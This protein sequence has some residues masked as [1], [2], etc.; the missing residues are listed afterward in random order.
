MHIHVPRLLVEQ[1]G[2]QSKRQE[3][4]D[5]LA[6]VVYL[7]A[8]RTRDEDF[9][10]LSH[11]FFGLYVRERSF[12]AL[13]RILL[14]W[15]ILECDGK[16]SARS[17]KKKSFGYRMTEAAA[18]SGL[19]P[20]EISSATAL[21]R[22]RQEAGKSRYRHCRLPVHRRL[23]DSL[24]TVSV[25]ETAANVAI[26][27]LDGEAK[28]Y[29]QV[30]VD[31]I[32]EKDFHWKPCPYDR[33]HSNITRLKRELRRCLQFEG[34]CL[35]EADIAC[36]QPL[37]LAALLPEDVRRSEDGKFYSELCQ[38]GELH[39]F[40]QTSL[41]LADKDEAKDQLFKYLF[42]PPRRNL[43]ISKLF[44]ETFSTI[45]AFVEATK[46]G[47][48]FQHYK[49][50]AQTMQRKEA[51]IVIQTICAELYARFPTIE[52]LTVHDSLLTTEKY[53]NEVVGVMRKIIYNTIDIQPQIRV[54][55]PQPPYERRFSPVGELCEATRSHRPTGVVR[56]CGCI[57]LD[58]AIDTRCGPFSWLSGHTTAGVRKTGRGQ[59]GCPC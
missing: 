35:F 34:K 36:S 18:M 56:H 55:P 6:L 7:V 57:R 50:L 2:F 14:A 38:Q 26:G 59:R 40:I 44:R 27:Q 19:S 29:S 42:G 32:V 8:S 48:R 12:P 3:V 16:Y 47:T 54:T 52:I 51:G 58:R 4:K 25:D 33:V 17:Y 1:E 45:H 28:Y 24:W 37:M 9:V 41:N 13:K 31:S 39:R 43:D 11:D 10:N 46:T 22:F 53:I 23:V 5:G 15:N 49:R 20:Y 30:V 21:R